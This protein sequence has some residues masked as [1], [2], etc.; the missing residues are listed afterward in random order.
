MSDAHITGRLVTL[1]ARRYGV[2]TLAIQN[3]ITGGPTFGY[4]PL[5]S[6]AFAAWGEVSRAWLVAG[7]APPERI[8]VVGSPYVALT[9]GIYRR[10]P[11]E[12]RQDVV[13]A[14]NNFDADQSRELAWAAAAYIRG[15]ADRRLVFRPHPAEG[16]ALYHNIIRRAGITNAV[17][18]KD[19]R[20][21]DVLAR[22]GVV[23]TAHSGVGVD[24]VV[25]GIP[26]VHVNLMAG[27]AD[28]IPY[29]SF[30]AALPVRDLSGLG[31]A[32]DDA[33]AEPA[34]LAQGRA[35]FAAAYLGR[36][37]GEPFTNIAGLIRNLV[38][39]PGAA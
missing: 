16:E 38:G 18:A 17:V 10:A 8:F 15:R 39:G 1:A 21:A 4:L 27:V 13:V 24:A 36:A 37:A 3:H 33:L 26:L 34:H 23:V 2:P 30:G 32:I 20:L 35:A 6:T 19:E 25:A 22:A 5:T 14:T 7:G 31:A 9:S 28:Y 12:H 11:K 29:A